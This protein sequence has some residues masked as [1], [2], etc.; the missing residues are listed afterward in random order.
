[1]SEKTGDIAQL[2]AVMNIYTHTDS[3]LTQIDNI[4]V[5]MQQIITLSDSGRLSRHTITVPKLGREHNRQNLSQKVQQLS[6]L[7]WEGMRKI[8]PYAAGPFMGRQ[9]K[10]GTEHTYPYP[11]CPTTR[12]SY[13]ES[14]R[15]CEQN[16][17]QSTIRRR[18]K[19]KK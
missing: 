10:Y 15:H 3:E 16:P 8:L 11:H 4:I 9:R 7:Q 6:H 19:D 13:I 1:M 17:F 5:I 18:D 2:M 14:I 12:Y